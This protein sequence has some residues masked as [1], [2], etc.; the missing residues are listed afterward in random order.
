MNHNIPR[1][2]TV[3]DRDEVKT[4]PS[5]AAARSKQHMPIECQHDQ[6]LAV[7]MAHGTD[8]LTDDDVRNTATVLFDAM[9]V[10]PDLT[11]LVDL[12]AVTHCTVSSDTIHVLADL[13]RCSAPQRGHARVAIVAAT[14]LAFG[15]SRMYATQVDGSTMD[16]SVFRDIHQGQAWLDQALQH[17]RVGAP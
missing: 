3:G 4:Q 7:I 16:V 8:R 6:D 9:A 10:T 13:H 14:D 17:D 5:I 12:R 2:A 15:L 11:I 1:S